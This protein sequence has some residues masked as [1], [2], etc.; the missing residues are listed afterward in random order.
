MSRLCHKIGLKRSTVYD[1]IARGKFPR[2]IQLVQGGRAVGWEEAAID[3][4][5]AQR[6][7]DSL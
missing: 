6:K 2:P 3:E 1:L 7:A 4:W 5:L